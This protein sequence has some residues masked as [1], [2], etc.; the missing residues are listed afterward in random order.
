[1]NE[2]RLQGRGGLGIRAMRIAEARGQL[3]GAL[4]VADTDEVLC[5]RS[6]G[7][8]TRSAVAEVAV[9]GR[10]TMGVRFVTWGA[11]STDEVLGIARSI[12]TE[13]VESALDEAA[14]VDAAAAEGTV[15]ADRHSEVQD[16]EV[17]DDSD[18]QDTSGNGAVVGDL[19]EDLPTDDSD[20]DTEHAGVDE[21][22]EA[23]DSEPS[24][25]DGGMDE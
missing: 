5:V 22:D 13:T 1:M 20:V 7:A 8:V 6:S 4:V 3:V 23:G 12:E 2:Y 17:Q 9:K 15:G 18:V 24:A 21:V 11:N 14:A 19:D 10:D 16:S 25:D